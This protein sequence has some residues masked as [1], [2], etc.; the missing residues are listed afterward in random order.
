MVQ[1]QSLNDELNRLLGGLQCQG[2]AAD[3]TGALGTICSF[4]GNSIG[5]SSGGNAGASPQNFGTSVQN[6][7]ER[8]RI[9]ERVVSETFRK[10]NWGIFFS[11]RVEALNK[12][13]TKFEDGFNSD[14]YGMLVGGD[15]RFTN[16]SVV[17]GGAFSWENTD[18]FFENG[19]DFVYNVYGPS[20]NISF[21]PFESMLLE[22]DA[23]FVR[24]EGG[25]RHKDYKV[26]R[27]ANHLVF[28][29]TNGDPAFVV[30]GFASSNTNGDIFS[31]QARVGYNAPLPGVGPFSSING[32]V[33]G[34]GNFS[35]TQI[36]GYEEKGGTGLDLIYEDQSINSWQSVGGVEISGVIPLS[37][38]VGSVSPYVSAEYIHEFANS[39]RKI[40]VQL[41]DD[42]PTDPTPFAFENQKP[43]RDFVNL[44]TGIRITLGN[45]VQ[46]NLDFWAMVGNKQYESYAGTVGLR[47]PL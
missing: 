10:E 42:S 8:N 23:L 33:W 35:N 9:E 6:R 3:T 7:A 12:D 14:V 32:S 47:F 37:N 22:D 27:P 15:Y 29:S 25:Y 40:N 18:G 30:D 24:L 26:K 21:E 19:G 1:A 45:G 28:D 43:E 17:I 46:G 44:G 2:L 31:A 20:G 4:T 13:T 34:G 39:Q 36:D 38:N 41:V 5:V 16:S 11:G